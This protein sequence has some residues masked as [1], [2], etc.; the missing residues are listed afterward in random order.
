[1]NAYIRISFPFTLEGEKR[2]S[3]SFVEFVDASAANDWANSF[4]RL[5]DQAGRRNV[6]VE[7]LAH[8]EEGN[9][10]RFE[11]AP[12]AVYAQILS[13]LPYSS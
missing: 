2:T 5:I 6:K 11:G 8:L 9:G 12:G 10:L 1:M 3:L 13:L 4:E 7:F